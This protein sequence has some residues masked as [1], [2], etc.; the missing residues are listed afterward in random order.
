LKTAEI[1]LC[2]GMQLSSAILPAYGEL[3]HRVGRMRRNFAKQYGFVVPDIKLS[4]DLSIPPKSY[5]IKMYGTV[6]A[7]G[8]LRIGDLL[9]ITGEGPRPEVPAEETREPAFGM[10]AFWVPDM[11]SEN[12]KRA[13]L[14]P[15]DTTTV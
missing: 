2:L 8:E 7:T 1:E 12:L 15:V 10:R 5:Q 4:D 11:F 14:K 6:V 3:A 13:G 9:V